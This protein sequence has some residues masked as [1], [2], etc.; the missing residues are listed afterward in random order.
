MT[1]VFRCLAL[2]AGSLVL[3]GQGTAAQAASPVVVLHSRPDLRPPPRV[4]ITKSSPLAAP[5]DV[6]LTPGGSGTM[7]VDGAGRLL[8]W[9]PLPRG[10][11]AIDLQA[12]T[13]R[14]Q[15]VLTWIERPA[16][17]GGN[18]YSGNARDTYAVVVD[19]RYRVLRRLHA[20]GRGVV[21][22]L[23]DFVLNPDG[24]ALLLGF[25]IVPRN[26]SSV[27]GPRRGHVVENLIQ[28]VDVATNRLRFDW[29]GLAH[30]PVS[31]SMVRV[32]KQVP[33]DYTH[34]NSV[35]L[36]GDGNIIAS[37][38]HTSTVYK[39]SR[40]NGGIIWRLGGKRST[41]RLGPGVQFYYQ[42][43][44]QPQPDGTY[45]IFDNHAADFD[46]RAKQSRVIRVRVDVARKTAT[47]AQQFTHP[48]GR[49]L[50]A[51]SQGDMQLL[52]G[53]NAFV[54]W[55]SAPWFSEYSPNGQLVFDGRLPSK[56]YQS[57]R[58]FKAVWHGLP[59]GGPVLAAS[60]KA[61]T[62]TAWASWN[63]ATDVAAW[64]VFAGPSARS[65]TPVALLPRTGF[66]TRIQVRTTQP[67]VQ[68]WGLDGAGRRLGGSVAVHPKTR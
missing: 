34:F 28:I 12:Q 11:T 4:T 19:S 52:A 46:L 43:D 22:D 62:V 27:H 16:I 29:H 31:E 26:L 68:V 51:V 6:F 17:T 61:G 30:V 37:A 65:L 45:S 56:S 44:A 53:G 9:R 32:R 64:S 13:Y 25:R 23:H 8:Y 41:F 57:Y 10:R 24:T 58:A 42:H 1:I 21:T 3:C 59:T 54:G 20:V 18:I 49:G 47:L 7:I 66:E 50:L 39:I 40:G 48:G 15:P 67:W 2:I 55:G 60:T 14:G 5:G 35:A 38:R 36:D 63:G 33:Y